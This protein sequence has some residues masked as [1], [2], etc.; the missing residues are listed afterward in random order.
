MI[1]KNTQQTP[2]RRLVGAMACSASSEEPQLMTCPR[3]AIKGSTAKP[4]ACCT[5]EGSIWASP[6]SSSFPQVH[7]PFLEVA[8]RCY[9]EVLQ[10]PARR[11]FLSP[12]SDLRAFG[13]LRLCGVRVTTDH[14]NVVAGKDCERSTRRHLKPQVPLPVVQ[15]L[16][17]PNQREMA[18]ALP[19]SAAADMA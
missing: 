11:F 12:S 18:G 13:V 14:E 10:V 19:V 3:P 17:E 15:D 2:Q 7:K 5:W 6:K 9:S 4:F 8:H 16:W 1:C